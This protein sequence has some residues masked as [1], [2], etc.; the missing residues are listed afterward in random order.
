[1]SII[2]AILEDRV[3]L[4][5]RRLQ[6]LIETLSKTTGDVEPVDTTN[7]LELNPYQTDFRQLQT[8]GSMRCFIA[9]LWGACL[10]TAVYGLLTALSVWTTCTAGVSRSLCGV[11]EEEWHP[12]P[13]MV[14]GT[15]HQGQ[16]APFEDGG[17][18][19]GR[20]FRCAGKHL[21]VQ[22]ASQIGT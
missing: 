9:G 4:R 21:R 16:R 5:L 17:L 22:L 12:I 20:I 10:E 19:G 3:H 1:M 11:W 15:L 7:T 2:N 13:R 6:D 18:E 14:H 8:G